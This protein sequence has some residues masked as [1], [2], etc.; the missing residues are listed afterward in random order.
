MRLRACVCACVPMGVHAHACVHTC[1]CGVCVCVRI[2]TCVHACMHAHAYVVYV[3]VCVPVGARARMRVNSYVRLWPV[4]CT[5]GGVREYRRMWAMLRVNICIHLARVQAHV[6]HAESQ[7]AF[8]W[9]DPV[10]LCSQA[11]SHPVLQGKGQ[12]WIGDLNDSHLRI[13]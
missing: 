2:C 3:Y 11:Q 7:H 8:T 1:M 4:V 6:G 5:Y 12:E 13:C 10:L 9:Q